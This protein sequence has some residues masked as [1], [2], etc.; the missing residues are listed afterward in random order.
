CVKA[1]RKRRATSGA[2]AGKNW[3]SINPRRT[4]LD[5][6]ATRL[7]ATRILPEFR[8]RRAGSR[9]VMSRGYGIDGDE[10][11]LLS[12]PWKHLSSRKFV[13]HTAR[14]QER[15]LICEM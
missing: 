4:R 13:R 10:Y 9:A 12:G 15:Q 1:Q 2:F 7:A 11:N 3:S 8:P 5:S 14:D 6:I